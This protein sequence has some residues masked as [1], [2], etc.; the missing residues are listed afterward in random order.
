MNKANHNDSMDINEL[1]FNDS[2]SPHSSSLSDRIITQEKVTP[3]PK[4]ILKK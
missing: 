4:N 2:M 3:K 1:S